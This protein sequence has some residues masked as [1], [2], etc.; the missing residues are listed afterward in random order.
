MLSLLSIL[1]PF[2]CLVRLHLIFHLSGW[3][4]L[5]RK[6]GSRTIINGGVA[7]IAMSMVFVVLLT[8]E[9]VPFITLY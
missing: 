3:M 8:V 4:M 6:V 7:A 1:S 2:I 5:S 9:S